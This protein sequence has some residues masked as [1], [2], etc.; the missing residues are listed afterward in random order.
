MPSYAPT[1]A[2]E[3]ALGGAESQPWPLQDLA[4][5]LKECRRMQKRTSWGVW[6]PL[7]SCFHVLNWELN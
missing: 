4:G 1:E 6:P 3:A 5:G 7:V 2:F